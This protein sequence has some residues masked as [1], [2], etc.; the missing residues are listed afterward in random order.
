M[1]LLVPP[2]IKNAVNTILSVVVDEFIQLGQGG[3]DVY[4]SHKKSWR[5][6]H[7]H[8]LRTVC[9]LPARKLVLWGILA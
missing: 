7:A 6:L 1:S 5:R 8:L 9:D 3:V 2:K 4:D